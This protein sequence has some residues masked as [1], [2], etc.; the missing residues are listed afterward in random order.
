MTHSTDALPNITVILVCTVILVRIPT[1]DFIV[2][3]C[4]QLLTQIMPFIGNP[5]GDR[6]GPIDD[7]AGSANSYLFLAALNAV[8]ALPLAVAPHSVSFRCLA[9]QSDSV[10]VVMG[11]CARTGTAFVQVRCL[12]TCSSSP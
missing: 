2:F 3:H 6:N 5:K 8:A 9:A 1:Q 12:A 10:A 7:A 4:E 11:L